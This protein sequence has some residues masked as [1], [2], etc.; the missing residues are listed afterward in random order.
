MVNIININTNINTNIININI[1]SINSQH[2]LPV[3]AVVVGSNRVSQTSLSSPNPR[4]SSLIFIFIFI[5]PLHSSSSD[6]THQL[7][8]QAP[9][10]YRHIL[11]RISPSQATLQWTIVYDRRDFSSDRH[12]RPRLNPLSRRQL[13]RSHSGYTEYRIYL[14]YWI[15][16]I[17]WIYLRILECT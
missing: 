15:Y 11:A 12:P 5:H 9:S 2:V 13:P 6:T 10:V 4:T 17:Y 7:Y 8:R 16:W 14:T 1:I 3:L